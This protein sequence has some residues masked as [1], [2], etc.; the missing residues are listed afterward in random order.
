[1]DRE[2]SHTITLYVTILPCVSVQC[3]QDSP[4]EHISDHSEHFPFSRVELTIVFLLVIVY[5][6]CLASLLFRALG[7]LMKKPPLNRC[8]QCL[9]W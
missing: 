1:M 6:T 4:A 7:G 9:V 8:I 3:L 2:V 5:L